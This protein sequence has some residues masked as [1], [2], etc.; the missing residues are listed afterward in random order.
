MTNERKGGRD[1]RHRVT[2]QSKVVSER[3]ALDAFLERKKVKQG[4]VGDDE[5]ERGEGAPLLDP[6]QNVDP[7]SQLPPEEGSHL[8]RRERTPHKVLEPSGEVDFVKDVADPLMV[9]GVEGF[10]SVEQKEDPI[11]LLANS[12][13]KKTIDRFY[14]VTTT[15]P[16]QKTF[17]GGVNVGANTWHD[18][19]GNGRCQNAVVGVGDTQG[20]CVRHQPSVLLREEEKETVVEAEGGKVALSNGLENVEEDRGS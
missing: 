8:D 15:R 16:Y 19:A 10:G 4:V 7:V 18:A 17:L 13:V 9:D 3:E 5:E 2:K 6:P 11:V 14:V 12:R 1:T 20:P